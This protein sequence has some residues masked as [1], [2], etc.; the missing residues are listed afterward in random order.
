MS[1]LRILVA[2]I[3]LYG[4]L[5][6]V[7]YAQESKSDESAREERETNR[8]PQPLLDRIFDRNDADQDGKITPNEVLAPP[9]RTNFEKVDVNGDGHVDRSEFDSEFPKHMRIRQAPTGQLRSGLPSA[10]LSRL[11]DRNDADGDGQITS[12]EAL[13]PVITR[14]F[15]KL[16]VDGNGSIDRKELEQELPKLVRLGPWR[17]SGRGRPR[18]VAPAVVRVLERAHFLQRRVDD[19]MSARIH[20]RVFDTLDPMKL[21][22]LQSDVDKFSGHEKLHDDALRKNDVS[23]AESVFARY[24]ERLS[25][26]IEWAVGYTNADFDFDKSN[27]R[28]VSKGIARYA[29]SKEEAKDRWRTEVKFKILERMVSGQGEADARRRVREEFQRLLRYQSTREPGAAAAVFLNALAK[30]YDPHSAFHS[31]RQSEEMRIRI[32]QSLEGIGAALRLEDGEIIVASIIPGGAADKDG[33]LTPDDRI[34]SIGEGIDGE[35]VSQAG[36][37][38]RDTV[39]FIRGE[40]GTTV[41]LEVRKPDGSREIC[42]IVREKIELPGLTS[43]V[44]EVASHGGT[45]TY[46]IGVVRVPSFYQQPGDDARS[47][48]TDIEEALEGFNDERIDA[49]L[50]DLR[51]NSG[52]AVGAMVKM[53]GLFLDEGPITQSRRTRDRLSVRSDDVPGQSYTGPL[54]VLVNRRSA[55]AAE[56]FSIAIQDYR[57]GLIIGDSQT[58]GKGTGAGRI[59]IAKFLGRSSEELGVLDVTRGKTYGPS[60]QSVHF[61]GV[62]SDI[63]LPSLTD[64]DSVGESSL[65]YSLPQDEIETA[66]FTPSG[67]VTEPMI[68]ELRKRSLKRREEDAG[69]VRIR[70]AKQ[71]WAARRDRVIMTFSRSL[72]ANEGSTALTKIHNETAG[73]SD[74]P[75]GS[76]AYEREVLRIVADLVCLSHSGNNVTS[77]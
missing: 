31:A 13:A 49:V 3:V 2:L 55:S 20:E 48:T 16:D 23:F 62:A 33:R 1:F 30:A 17:G 66:Q 53:A 59:D 15:Q 41:R 21:H 50:V 29:R 38:L 24:L 67:D 27:Q 5:Y 57:R 56:L 4:T 19:E 7:G 11:I 45:N 44:V 75:F 46:R 6:V 61:S 32:R 22:F 42:G 65:K 43:R 37:L 70:D 47:V 73:R 76:N 77:N 18:D 39:D 52:G 40:A 69:F 51:G 9:L 25:E 14:N 64:W 63:V 28:I 8:I 72:L 36:A 26:R 68:S 34:L 10:M 71:Q 12:K 54:A 35:L 74:E 60:G 58:F